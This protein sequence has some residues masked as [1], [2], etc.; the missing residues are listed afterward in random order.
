MRKSIPLRSTMEFLPWI[1][2][3]D[4]E[5]GWTFLLHYCHIEQALKLIILLQIS[6]LNNTEWF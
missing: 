1:G 6:P 5:E 4:R 3:V 2:R